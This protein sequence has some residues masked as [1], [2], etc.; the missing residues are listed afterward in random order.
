MEETGKSHNAGEILWY[1]DKRSELHHA[2][3]KLL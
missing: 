1:K 3:D 2:R